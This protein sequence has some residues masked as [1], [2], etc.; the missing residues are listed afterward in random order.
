[1]SVLHPMRM[2]QPFLLIG[3]GD[4]TVPDGA[5]T[6][7]L[8]REQK[9]GT[10]VVMMTRQ[11]RTV[12]RRF[13]DAVYGSSEAARAQARAYRD[14]VIAVLPPATNLERSARLHKN[15]TSGM[16]G[17][18]RVR[19]GHSGFA[20]RA[21]LELKHGTRRKSFS[22]N[23][24]GEERARDLAMA[25][26]ET[27]LAQY[28]VAFL[29]QDYYGRVQAQRSFADRLTRL[30]EAPVEEIPFKQDAEKVEA[31]LA[32]I[33]A[34]FDAMRP[35]RLRVSV[36]PQ[37]YHYLALLVSDGG[38]QGAAGRARRDH[39]VLRGSAS[40][41]SRDLSEAL[42]DVTS[43]IEAMIARLYDQDVARW[44]MAYHAGLLRDPARFEAEGGLRVLAVLPDSNRYCRS[45]CSSKGKAVPGG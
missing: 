11:G 43:R 7:G 23:K 26:R 17:V 9:T 20:W 8:Y 37:G 32:A 42:T 44:F 4:D 30:A 27:W 10:F 21:T 39:K 31:R 28:P 15:N 38:L 18:A 35:R 45:A 22:V 25:E 33:E 41:R 40:F 13:A 34:R 29:T 2:T 1:M 3:P 14:A 16:A 19:M 5:E 24:Y 6:Y 12:L 36:L